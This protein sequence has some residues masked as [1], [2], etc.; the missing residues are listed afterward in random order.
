M[1]KNQKKEKDK[2][3]N[4]IVRVLDTRRAYN[5]E[6]FLGRLKMDPWTLRQDIL[7]L[8]EN[9]LNLDTVHKLINFVPTTDESQQLNGYENEKNLGVAENFI[10]II[11]TVD[12]NLVERLTL[13]E[14]KMEFTEKYSDQKQSLVWLR[15]GHDCIKKSVGLKLMFTLILKIG[16]YMNG[17]TSKGQAY[18]FKIGSLS[19]LMRSRTVD[20]SAT[21]M[22]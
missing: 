11:R 13:W 22:E 7:S 20:N 3:K 15:N 8:N 5:I 16:N 14:F 12:K 2:S 4:E 10:K 18:G 6:I 21:L 1:I 19:Q 9:K 17:S